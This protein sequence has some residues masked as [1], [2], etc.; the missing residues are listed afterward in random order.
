M[1]KIL[2]DNRISKNE[3]AIK[4]QLK[5]L[6][7]LQSTFILL[8]TIFIGTFLIFSIFAV[9]PLKDDRIER[10][11]Q[12]T[13]AVGFEVNSMPFFPSRIDVQVNL[14]NGSLRADFRLADGEN[15][16]LQSSKDSFKG[17]PNKYSLSMNMESGKYY[18]VVENITDGPAGDEIDLHNQSVQVHYVISIGFLASLYPYI[19]LLCLIVII[20]TFVLLFRASVVKKSIAAELKKLSV[21]VKSPGAGAQEKQPQVPGYAYTPLHGL[22]QP[23]PP[24]QAYYPPQYPPEPDR[25]QYYPP[26]PQ[27]QYPDTA[28]TGY[29]P[30]HGDG[31]DALRKTNTRK[32]ERKTVRK[33]TVPAT[34]EQPPQTTDR[35]AEEGGELL[36]PSKK[37][38]VKQKTGGKGAEGKA[39]RTTEKVTV[40][41]CQLCGFENKIKPGTGS[42]T[43]QLCGHAITNDN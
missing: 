13:N 8:C 27:P 42:V 31:G 5:T 10:I 32:G 12:S 43:C 4:N 24:A 17:K 18:L 20:V 36:K 37:M 19:I 3:G 16:T 33:Q 40:V 2:F 39:Q 6:Q 30:Q 21:G 11:D 1:F 14:V 7:K 25:R 35:V 15:T 22:P 34:A 38:V 23:Q 9:T 41:T 28:Q 29:P 26:A